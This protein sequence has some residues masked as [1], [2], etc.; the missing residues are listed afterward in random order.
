MTAK[1]ASSP[2]NGNSPTRPHRVLAAERREKA[3]AMRIGGATY[4]QIGKHLGVTKATVY[5]TIL[6]AL[7]QN[8]AQVAES[9]AELREIEAQRLDALQ[10]ALWSDAMKGDEQKVDRILRVMAR[11][12][13]LFGLD[14][15]TKQEVVAKVETVEAYDYNAAI[16]PV[17][18]AS[19]A[20]SDEITETAG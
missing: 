9:A 14:A 3:V 12:A 5:R 7:K 2:L 15:P 19:P 17:L 11:R 13:A 4:E 20:E 8:A 6:E 10:A 18:S 1:N 16:A